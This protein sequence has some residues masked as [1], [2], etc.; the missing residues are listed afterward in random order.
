MLCARS[1]H[2][3]RN[4]LQLPE[5]VLAS[6]GVNTQSVPLITS[7]KRE[8]GCSRAG[9]TPAQHIP[10]PFQLHRNPARAVRCFSQGGV[11][12]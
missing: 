5:Q 4:F 7:T 1:G 2:F 8:G 10:R 3:S 6:C 9:S 11:L 12:F